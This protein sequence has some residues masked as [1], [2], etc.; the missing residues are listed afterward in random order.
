VYNCTVES[1]QATDL[2]RLHALY[3]KWARG[4]YSRGDIF[5]REIKSETIGMGDPIR[6]GNYEEFVAAM[7]E[8]LS[9][10][11]RPLMIEA[12]EYIQSGDRILVLIHWR[13][14]GKGSGAQI[15]GRGAHLWTF[16]E[17]LAVRFDTYRDRDQARAALGG[18]DR[19]H[20]RT[21][22]RGVAWFQL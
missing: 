9:A 3:G 16:R 13:G 20:E 11:E 6:A 15:E 21:P 14:R 12:E 10:W 1:S 17:G 5:D 8:W 4:D 2:E 19:A 7:R 22:F 18:G